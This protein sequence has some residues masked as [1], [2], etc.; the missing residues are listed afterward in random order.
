[1]PKSMTN[2][3]YTVYSL[4][5]HGL[6]FKN[7]TKQLAVFLISMTNAAFCPASCHI[8]EHLQLFNLTQWV[9]TCYSLD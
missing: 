3:I 8:F 5:F 2:T 9:N 1:M 6:F 7:Q 4:S